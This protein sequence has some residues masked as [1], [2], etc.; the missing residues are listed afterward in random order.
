M[1]GRRDLPLEQRFDEVTDGTGVQLPEYVSEKY[2]PEWKG[3]MH[4]SP[5]KQW[6]VDGPRAQRHKCHGKYRRYRQVDKAL[7]EASGE[8]VLQHG[9]MCTNPD[10]HGHV[11]SPEEEGFDFDLRCGAPGSAFGPK[12]LPCKHWAECNCRGLCFAGRAS[13]G[14][15]GGGP[16]CVEQLAKICPASCVSPPEDGHGPGY[17]RPTC[18]P[19]IPLPDGTSATPCGAK[20]GNNM[21]CFTD[22]NG[23]TPGSPDGKLAENPY[24]GPGCASKKLRDQMTPTKDSAL[25]AIHLWPHTGLPRTAAGL[26]FSSGRFARERMYAMAVQYDILFREEDGALLYVISLF[27]E[28]LCRFRKLRLTV[29]LLQQSPSLP[30]SPS[31][32]FQAGRSKGSSGRCRT[33]LQGR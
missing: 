12:S 29:L 30:L 23:G 1:E 21:R 9:D 15:A 22:P 26:P 7:A 20:H 27:L 13:L 17:A 31:L 10:K 16:A 8:P 6:G 4:I 2:W 5:G 11:K 33:F 32:R 18:M 19:M 14:K 25:N 3:P 28:Q 24:A